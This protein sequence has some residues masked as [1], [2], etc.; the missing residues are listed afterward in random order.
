MKRPWLRW[1]IRIGLGICGVLLATA[2]AAVCFFGPEG[3]LLL[4]LVILQPLISTTQPPPMFADQIAGARF[5]Q[6]LTPY[7]QQEFPTGTDESLVRRTLLK[8]GFKPPVPPPLDCWPQGKPAPV[9][10]VIFLCPIHD[11]GKILGYRWERFPCAYTI[12]VW[13]TPEDKGGISR[14][15]GGYDEACL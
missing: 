1:T 12:N 11:P 8:Q 2:V 4:A 5:Q 9:G 10:K 13:W 6:D 3:A 15:G 14:I 7:L